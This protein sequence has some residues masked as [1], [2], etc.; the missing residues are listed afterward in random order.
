MKK[1]P[2]LHLFTSTHRD[3]HRPSDDFNKLNLAGMQRIAT[4]FTDIVMDVDDREARPEYLVTKRGK[5]PSV[6]T[7]NWPDFGSI[8]DYT[9]TKNFVIQGVRKGS[10]AAKA[11]IKAGDIMIQFGPVKIK[12]VRDFAAALGNSKVGQKVKV[13]VLRKKQKVTVTVTLGKRK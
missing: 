13:V 11:G 2:V 10:P 8:P 3:Y 12:T 6:S 4:F 1:I 7:G 5:R 9:N